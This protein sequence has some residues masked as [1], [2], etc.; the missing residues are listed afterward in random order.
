MFPGC[1]YGQTLKSISKSILYRNCSTSFT[2]IFLWFHA[3]MDT[4]CCMLDVEWCRQDNEITL[5]QGGGR[6]KVCLYNNILE[7]WKFSRP[8][9]WYLA[10]RGAWLRVILLLCPTSINY[11]TVM[12]LVFSAV[13]TSPPKKKTREKKRKDPKYP[14][15]GFEANN[16]PGKAMSRVQAAD[17]LAGLLRDACTTARSK[18]N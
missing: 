5:H 2:F 11:C 3:G 1:Y 13:F 14:S 12:R 16:V 18:V 15:W 4:Q 9:S 6:F 17:W 7:F 10:F 8:K